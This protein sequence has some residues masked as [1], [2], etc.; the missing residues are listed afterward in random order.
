LILYEILAVLEAQAFTARA[1]IY[2]ELSKS[3]C[4]V[5]L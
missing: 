4:K 5:E 3:G 2:R 1:L